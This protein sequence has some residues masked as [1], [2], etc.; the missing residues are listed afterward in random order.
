MTA[1][2]SFLAFFAEQTLA[3]AVKMHSRPGRWPSE[4]RRAEGASTRSAQLRNTAQALAQRGAKTSGRVILVDKPKVCQRSE[5]ANEL[6]KPV[7][8]SFLPCLEKARG[9]EEKIRPRALFCPSRSY[10]GKRAKEQEAVRVIEDFLSVLPR[11]VRVET[12]QT[13]LEVRI[14]AGKRIALRYL[15]REELLDETLTQDELARLVSRLLE[16]SLYA[17]ESELCEGFFTLED[18]SR[19]GVCGRYA[20]RDGQ[21]EALVYIGSLCLRIAREVRGCAEP[22]RALLGRETGGVLVLSPPGLG[23]T[24]LLRDAARWMSAAG[25]NVAIADERSEIAACRHGVPGFD[26]GG[27]VDVMDGCHKVEAIARLLRSMAPEALVTDEVGGEE[28]ARALLDAARCGVKLV[29][30]AHAGDLA[31]ARRRPAIARMLRGGAF[32]HAVVMGGRAG[33]IREILAL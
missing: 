24:T 4:A 21:I 28:D 1:C 23:K 25:L 22:I 20:A 6:V 16:H 5:A 14:R 13:L 18:G 3:F 26:L 7:R 2:T 8:G 17:W 32:A 27:R 15:D 12:P 9:P 30:S 19:V 31:D 10:N 29:A 33:H 11:P